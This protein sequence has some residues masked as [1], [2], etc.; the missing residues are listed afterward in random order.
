MRI[1]I[2][3]FGGVGRAFLNLIYN[4][5]NKLESEGI[6]FQV[7]YIIGRTGGVY[8]KHGIDLHKFIN[9]LFYQKDITKYCDGGKAED[10]NFEL[11]LNNKDI[12]LMVE[13]T[14]TNK[15]TG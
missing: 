10:I 3:G 8:N 4:K 6:Y 5:K 14:P 11:M 9:F 12:D 7:N 13:M 1:G 15:E 2:V